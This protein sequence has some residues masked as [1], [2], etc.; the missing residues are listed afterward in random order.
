MPDG[1]VRF[2]TIDHLIAS[3]N[4]AL[5]KSN[6]ARAFVSSDA[7]GERIANVPATPQQLDYYAILVETIK[8]TEQNSAHLRHLVYERAR[9]NFKRDVLFGHSTL[10]LSDL[11]RHINDFELAV[12]RIEANATGE[13]LHKE[14]RENGNGH[15]ANSPERPT[16]DDWLPTANASA[17]AI[18]PSD[19]APA[20]AGGALQILPPQPLPPLYA[21]FA[22]R[23]QT[24]NSSYA[25]RS[26]EFASYKRFTTRLVGIMIAG[27]A[28]V[29][30]IIFVGTYWLSP[31][32]TKQIIIA[33]SSSQTEGTASK[34]NSSREPPAV[35]KDDSVKLPYPL[36]TSFGIYV[37]SDNKLT[38]LQ[39]LAMNVPDQRIALS[40]EI[41]TS[42]TTTISDNKPSFILF[43]RDLVN[44]VPQKISLRV[45]ARVARERKIVDGKGKSTN[46]EETWR[47]RN[48]SR[49]LRV[50]P[51]PGQR[52]MVIAHLEENNSLAAGRYELALN[53]I[54][55]DFTVAG[56]IK[57][58]THY[59]ERFELTTGP[60]YTEC[61][62]P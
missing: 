14:H 25:R 61:Q 53:R 34:Q 58:P 3:A 1:L 48:I 57:S 32:P 17:E 52:E 20:S 13:R 8:K 62:T 38:E 59:L 44:S 27:I 29:G 55:Y 10:G 23:Q 6:A 7:P 33:D 21:G 51:I 11:V 4:G 37:L 16:Q 46:I 40:A 12:A 35:Q 30:V 41:K 60:I 15:V 28:L 56:P 49:E 45:V 26:E 5:A 39:A 9:F 19:T 50:S 42:S 43:R 47:I 22:P 54:G 31:R 18:E 2:K 24:G 36:P